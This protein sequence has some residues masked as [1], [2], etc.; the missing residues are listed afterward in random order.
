M[1]LFNGCT[2]QWGAP[3]DG[4]GERYGGVSSRED[5]EAL[6]E[7]LQPGCFWR[8]DWFGGADNPGVTFQEVE[9]PSEITAKSG[10]QRS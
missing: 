10:C 2:T 3:E 5:C 9:C 7:K 6:P 1:G 8:F 4:W